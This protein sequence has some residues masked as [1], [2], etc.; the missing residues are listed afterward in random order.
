MHYDLTVVFE[1]LNW[2]LLTNHHFPSIFALTW[3]EKLKS[4]LFFMKLFR[5]PSHIS[6]ISPRLL[7]TSTHIQVHTSSTSSAGSSAC[8]WKETKCVCAAE[9]G[10]KDY[11]RASGEEVEWMR[12]TG[13]HRT[14]K[15]GTLTLPNKSKCQ[16][17]PAEW[18]NLLISNC[19]SVTAMTRVT[20]NFFFFFP[21]HHLSPRGPPA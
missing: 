6:Y 3:V 16:Q 20:D 21:S 4:N 10:T 15:P 8:S 9:C 12:E 5:F 14:D 11:F 13:R 19:G 1:I 7:F 2:S 18:S 17:M